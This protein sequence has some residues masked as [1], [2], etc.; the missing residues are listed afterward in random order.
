MTANLST[1][2]NKRLGV[3]YFPDTSH[4]QQSDLQNWLPELKYLGASWLTL[5]A[6]SDHAIPE[7]FINGLMAEGIQPIL[8]FQLPLEHP[9]SL[10]TLKLL[11]QTY[12]KWGVQYIILFDRPNIRSAWASTTWAQSDLV[13]R[14][15]DI[16]L[17]LADIILQT[18]LIPVFPP[19]EP[20][21]DYWDTAFLRAALQS[22]QRRGQTHLLE[23]LILSANAWV[24]SRPLDWGAGGPER[25]PNA[26]PYRTPVDHQDQRGFYIFDWYLAISQSVLGNPLPVILVG[27][28]SRLT[29]TNDAEKNQLATENHA[30]RNLLLVQRLYN[31]KEQTQVPFSLEPISPMVMACNFWLLVAEPNNQHATQA[32]FLSDGSTL[33]IVEALKD[34]GAQ[35]HSQNWSRPITHPQQFDT[36][37]PES[38]EPSIDHYLLL[39]LY[40]WGVAEWQLEAIRP[41]VTKYRPTVGFSL[42]EASRASRVTV[43]G[44]KQSYP[45]GS[46]DKLHE[47]GCAVEQ[48]T[49][50]GT[51]IATQ[52][53]TL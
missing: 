28:G 44:G 32:W 36:L 37:Q 52:L 9:E 47:A 15:L 4:Y 43:I 35:R 16:Y 39:P 45:E 40:E 11:F 34:W 51:S 23:T 30:K 31:N 8:H 18:G 20:G 50:D 12:A 13:E 41:F 29:L 42:N 3:H 14:F 24:D 7:Q 1:F 21:G 2:S 17:P 49:G 33:P 6:P 22:M 38:V 5:V 53:A 25:W 27:A 10:E 48:I 26:R 19:L 46:I